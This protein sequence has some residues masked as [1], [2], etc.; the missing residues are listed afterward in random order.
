MSKGL[1]GIKWTNQPNEKD[2]RFWL[3]C[4]EGGSSGGCLSLIKLHDGRWFVYVSAVLFGK[5]RN[6]SWIQKKA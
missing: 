1:W 4:N 3:T 6:R 5:W 2:H